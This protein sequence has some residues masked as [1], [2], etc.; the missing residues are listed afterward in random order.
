MRKLASALLSVVLFAAIGLIAFLLIWHREQEAW[1]TITGLLAVIAAVIAA[2]PALRVL[3]LQDDSSR[4]RP[5]PYF[6]LSSRYQLLQLR[7]KNIGPSV[8][9]DVRLKWKNRPQDY[10][11]EEITVLDEIPVLLPDQSVSTNMG[12][13]IELVKKYSDKRFEGEA[14]FKDANGR[15]LRQK[16]VCSTQEHRKRLLHDEELPRTLYDLQKIPEKLEKIVDTLREMREDQR[17][18]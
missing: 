14:E 3:E 13:S 8:A 17:G 12:T 18:R 2:W 7:V 6:D 10:K 11:G 5:T 9:Y 4:P 1:A 16:F 15:S